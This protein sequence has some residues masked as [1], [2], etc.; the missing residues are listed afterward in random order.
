MVRKN[1]SGLRNV[2]RLLWELLT[3]TTRKAEKSEPSREGLGTL[4]RHREKLFPMF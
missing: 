1:P 4:R 2:W 3:S